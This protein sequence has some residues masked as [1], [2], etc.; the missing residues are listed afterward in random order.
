MA[1]RYELRSNPTVEV[2]I[3][4]RKYEAALGNI[5]FIIEAKELGGKMRAISEPGISTDEIVARAED[6]SN[7]ARAMCASM[8]GE[9]A[10]DELLGGTHR[11]DLTRIADIISIMADVAGSEASLDAARSA[12]AA[13]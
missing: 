10:A 7:S 3:D 13:A 5:T 1:K 12:F 2:E 4:G 9:A 8:F 6:F 11:L